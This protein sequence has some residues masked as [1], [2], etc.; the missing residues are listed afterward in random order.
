MERKILN[1]AKRAGKY[2]AHEK[3]A[4]VGVVIALYQA[5]IL[6]DDRN[7]LIDECI[8]I[9]VAIG[10]DQEFV[11]SW[12][13]NGFPKVLAAVIEELHDMRGC[14]VKPLLLRAVNDHLTTRHGV[15]HRDDVVRRPPR[16]RR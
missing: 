9:C 10:E 4:A 8:E 6:R 16:R 7:V 1:K 5:D 3:W 15:A 14:H 13:G 12:K 11:E 2:A